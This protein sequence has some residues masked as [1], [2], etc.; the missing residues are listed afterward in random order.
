MPPFGCCLLVKVLRFQELRSYHV[1]QLR[2]VA[3]IKGLSK[4]PPIRRSVIIRVEALNTGGWAKRGVAGQKRTV[5]GHRC[6]R[7]CSWYN[8]LA[9]LILT[10]YLS[11]KSPTQP[12]RP[13]LSSD[14][15]AYSSNNRST[16]ICISSLRNTLC[17][18]SFPS[19]AIFSATESWLGISS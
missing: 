18:H 2:Y 4:P 17:A 6:A 3:G 16:Y 8:W 10:R 9:N 13:R 15:R 11:I 19:F 7:A 14:T 12:N 5:L 1:G